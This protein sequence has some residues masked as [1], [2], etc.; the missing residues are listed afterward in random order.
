[1]QTISRTDQGSYK[2]C[3]VSFRL[4]TSSRDM[5]LVFS[6]ENIYPTV[7]LRLLRADLLGFFG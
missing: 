3:S 6:Q 4:S 1:M 7:T 2:E 5:N